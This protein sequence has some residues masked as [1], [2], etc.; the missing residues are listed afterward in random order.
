MMK[1]FTIILVSAYTICF[2]SV[3]L[4]IY[5][6]FSGERDIMWRY[7]WISEASWFAVFSMFVFAIMILMRPN[8]K[9][10]LLA[11]VEELR[12]SDFGATG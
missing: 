7:E 11:Y 8:S 3:V 5:L 6:K 10:K 2:L 4:E 1:K 12:E 9:S